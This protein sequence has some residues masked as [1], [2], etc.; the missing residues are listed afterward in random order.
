MKQS[1]QKIVLAAGVSFFFMGS[2]SDVAAQARVATSAQPERKISS[3]YDSYRQQAKSFT[4]QAL[5]ERLNDPTWSWAFMKPQHIIDEILE[6]A[7]NPSSYSEFLAAIPLEVNKNGTRDQ[8]VL[9]TFSTLLKNSSSVPG[10]LNE[11]EM[12]SLYTAACKVIN[13]RVNGCDSLRVRLVEKNQAALSS[14]YL[15]KSISYNYLP[16]SIERSLTER[17]LKMEASAPDLLKVLES[18]RVYAHRSQQGSIN[19]SYILYPASYEKDGGEFLK[20]RDVAL[21]KAFAIDPAATVSACRKS[22]LGDISAF[23][24]NGLSNAEAQAKGIEALLKEEAST[25]A[26]IT[27]YSTDLEYAD[28]RA[29]IQ[30]IRNTE[31]E[32]NES[33]ATYQWRDGLVRKWENALDT[34]RPMN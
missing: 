32:A 29:A 16:A 33:Y 7:K 18:M 34:S 3:V 9:D 4:N 8:Y 19:T 13:Y 14:S 12:E 20:M 11:S 15:A 23:V 22:I 1:T 24:M 2:H 25:M 28:F 21:E 17:L 27:S 5:V 30:K 26:Y 6:R 10:N 31:T